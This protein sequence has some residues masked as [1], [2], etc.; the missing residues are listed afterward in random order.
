MAPE[1]LVAPGPFS[2]RPFNI[3]VLVKRFW[4]QE[5]IFGN[6]WIHPLTGTSFRLAIKRQAASLGGAGR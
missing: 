4:R 1:G 6:C 3:K 5:L 2:R